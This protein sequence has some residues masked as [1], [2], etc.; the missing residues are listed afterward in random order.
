MGIGEMFEVSLGLFSE[1]DE[2]LNQI[3]FPQSS[4][5]LERGFLVCPQIDPLFALIGSGVSGM[6]LNLR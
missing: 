5:L 3:G 4:F 1:T 6:T 2:G